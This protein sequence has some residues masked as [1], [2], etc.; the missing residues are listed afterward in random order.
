MNTRGTSQDRGD[1]SE[2]L[3][4]D[5]VLDAIGRG[6]HVDSSDPLIALLSSARSEV[7]AAMPAPPLLAELLVEDPAPD[8]HEAETAGAAGNVS[9]LAS[10][11]RRRLGRGASAAAAGGASITSMMVAGGVAAAIAVG[12]L[13]YAAYSGIQPERDKAQHVHDYADG[14]SSENTGTVPGGSDSSSSSSAPRTP[15]SPESKKPETTRETSK[16]SE[17][18]SS[19]E[20]GS[21]SSEMPMDGQILAEELNSALRDPS[22]SDFPGYAPPLG[23][24]GE[25]GGDQPSANGESQE[26]ELPGLIA[27]P[28]MNAPA[29]EEEDDGETTSTTSPDKDSSTPTRGNLGNGELDIQPADPGYV[30]GSKTDTD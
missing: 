20:E 27:A 22:L 21:S 23:L 6:E 19:S 18:S 29:E 25:Q 13:G 30:R 2:V 11:R 24:G 5:R 15:E 26:Q 1:F 12:G 7:D 10:R 28:R 8:E 17:E 14:G 16:E 9:D 3:A 4:E